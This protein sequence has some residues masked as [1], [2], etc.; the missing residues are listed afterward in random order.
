MKMPY[1]REVTALIHL[2]GLGK[3]P[4]AAR[5]RQQDLQG[6]GMALRPPKSAGTAG[7]VRQSAHRRY[8]VC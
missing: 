4:A 8:R 2:D 3:E 1:R 7:A 6:M 5:G